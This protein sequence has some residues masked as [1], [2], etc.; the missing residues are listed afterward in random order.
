MN[1]QAA[2]HD[3]SIAVIRY[4]TVCKDKFNDINVR[5]LVYIHHDTIKNID[6]DMNSTTSPYTKGI[7]IEF[8]ECTLLLA[9][10]SQLEYEQNG[11]LPIYRVNK[12][13]IGSRQRL[14]DIFVMAEIN[15]AHSC[16]AANF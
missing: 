9:P 4:N 11:S 3:L 13:I 10:N 7:C 1:K 5:E 16:A 14:F 15:I 12:T 2:I 6:Y 8:R